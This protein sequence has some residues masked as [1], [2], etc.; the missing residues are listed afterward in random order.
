MS[1]EIRILVRGN[2]LQS[3]LCNGIWIENKR[4]VPLWPSVTMN[5]EPTESL[6]IGTNNELEAD[7]EQERIV[8]LWP[9]VRTTTRV[10]SV[11]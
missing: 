10:D 11:G 4:T 3:R 6:T 2:I 8:P 5:R 9:S 1:Q 7:E